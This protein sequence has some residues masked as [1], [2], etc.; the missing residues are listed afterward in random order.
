MIFKPRSLRTS[1]IEEEIKLRKEI[2]EESKRGKIWQQK[3]TVTGKNKFSV[4]GKNFLAS[5]QLT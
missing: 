4:T 2:E 1:S 3:T 5:K